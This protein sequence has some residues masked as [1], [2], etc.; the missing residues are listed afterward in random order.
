MKNLAM[1]LLAVAIVTPALAQ[2]PGLNQMQRNRVRQTVAPAVKPILLHTGRPITPDQ[3]RQVQVSAATSYGARFPGVNSRMKPQ[4]TSA[5][6]ARTVTLSWSSMF[7]TGFVD[8]EWNNPSY[9]NPELSQIT[10]GPGESSYIDFIFV[11][12]ANTTY[13]MTFKVNAFTQNPQYTILPSLPPGN[14]PNGSET[15]AGNNGN[16]EFAY[17]FVSDAAGILIVSLYSS[18]AYWVLDSCEIMATPIS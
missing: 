1:L 13:T 8:T 5:P 11:A 16:D 15:F 10:F 12:T 17:S 2:N 6:T 4:V 7:Q 18:N 3:K 9:V 14:G